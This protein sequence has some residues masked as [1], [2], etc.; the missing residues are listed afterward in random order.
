MVGTGVVVLVQPPTVVA[1]ATGFAVALGV[2]TALPR[3]W[4]GRTI[5]I[6]GTALLA[7]LT[8]LG[9]YGLAVDVVSL[10]QQEPPTAPLTF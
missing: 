5:T 6:T 9:L 7:A 1:A 3:W 8:L 4:R 2:A 10:V